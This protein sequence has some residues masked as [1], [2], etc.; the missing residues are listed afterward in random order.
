VWY[1]VG[2]APRRVVAHDDCPGFEGC[3]GIGRRV[4][5]G[6]RSS[7][8]CRFEGVI[9]GVL[10]LDVDDPPA[11]ISVV[12]VSDTVTVG[13]LRIRDPERPRVVGLSPPVG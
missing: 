13:H 6:P 2:P 4:V 11:S 7:V 1:R 9:H 12:A 3:D 10:L 5:A 8:S